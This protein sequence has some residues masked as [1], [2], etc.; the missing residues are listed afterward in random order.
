VSRRI[1][2]AGLAVGGSGLV[3]AQTYSVIRGPLPEPTEFRILP[4]P[5]WGWPIEAAIQPAG[6]GGG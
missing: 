1:V 6:I 5:G 2:S 3:T 4:P